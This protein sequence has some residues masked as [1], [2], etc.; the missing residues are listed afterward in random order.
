MDLVKNAHIITK[1]NIKKTLHSQ[2][3][4][5]ICKIFSFE[6][7]EKMHIN[8]YILYENNEL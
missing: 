7:A 8:V 6:F 2:K 1:K 3:N 5:S 4:D